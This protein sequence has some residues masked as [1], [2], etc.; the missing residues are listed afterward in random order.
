MF[1][2][3]DADFRAAV[4]YNNAVYAAFRTHRLQNDIAAQISDTEGNIKPFVDFERDVEKY[5][6]PTHLRAW[7]KT[8][9]DTTVRRIHLAADWRRFEREKDI[10]P[11]LRWI[12]S[13]S[14]EPGE[15]H[16]VFWNIVRSVNDS[17]WSHHCPG[18]R[19]NC[20]CGLE[21]TDSEITP[22]DKL[23]EGTSKDIPMDGL[24][25]N[26]AIDG[27]VFSE[28][29]P[30]Q[31]HP[32]KGAEKA[33]SDLIKENVRLPESLN[34][35]VYKKFKNG[36]E[37]RIYNEVDKKASDYKDHL[38]IA[39]NQAKEGKVAEVMPRIHYKD[40]G[41]KELYGD[42]IG[43]NYERKCPDLRINGVFYEFESFVPP[44]KLRKISN[45]ISNGLKQS[46]RI[47]INNNNTGVSDGYILR[48]IYG[49][50]KE[51]INIEEVWV[52]EKKKIRIVY[53]KQ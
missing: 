50:I 40:E 37:V 25:N 33:V 27:K 10:L 42:L 29:N 48:S 22:D 24:E 39:T 23:P 35:T 38:T 3:P 11:N 12:P 9:Y 41:Y 6:E 34:F 43:T 30:Y 15:D 49:R 21:A 17:F 8:E 32:Y 53:K 47:I 52:L 45:M 7:L 26:P 4:K 2:S 16:R 51:D 13:T 1:G 36:G 31:K 19:W 18:D 28:N 14:A 44:F 46:S 5:V 20:K